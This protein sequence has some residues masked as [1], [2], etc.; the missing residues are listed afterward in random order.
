MINSG[1]SASQKRSQER[2]KLMDFIEKASLAH[3][4]KNFNIIKITVVAAVCLTGLILAIRSVFLG[5]ILYMFLYLIADI[6][7][8][9][10]VIIK[11]NTIMPS[12]FAV[13]ED[14]IVMQCWDNG[15]FPYNINFKPSFFADFVPAKVTKKEIPIAD[16]S[17]IYVGSKN[18]LVRNLEETAFPETIK[19]VVG[20][21]RTDEDAVRKMDFIC[22]IKKDGNVEYMSVTNTEADDLAR[23]VNYI[24]KKNPETEIKCNLRELRTKLTIDR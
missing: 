8:I 4:K 20:S 2:T 17:K 21:R 1:G 9:S 5:N 19:K 7:G 15:V 3:R 22:I 10:Y 18:Y 11:I 12:Y 13:T 16:V 14:T 23:A 6:L 24:F